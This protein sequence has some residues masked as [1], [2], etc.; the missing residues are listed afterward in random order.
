M[1]KENLEYW[2]DKDG[3]KVYGDKKKY[4][5]CLEYLISDNPD[6][7][8]SKH[9]IRI[10]KIFHP[11]FVKLLPLTTKN[12][13][14]VERRSKIPKGRPIIF[15]ASHGFRDDIALSL[16][17]IKKHAYLVYA[18]IPDFYY[19]IDGLALWANGVY[20]MDRKDKG[21][22]AALIPKVK[23]GFELGAKNV[24]ICSEGVWN[25]DPNEPILEL[26][27]GVYKM[28]Q[29]LNAVVMPVTT[30]NKDMDIDN[31]KKKACYS[32]LG[33]PIDITK[34]PQAEALDILRSTMAL[35]KIELMQKYSRAKR[36]DI[37]DPNVYWN[38][39]VQ[40]L[41]KTSNGL[42]DY[43]I[44][45]DAEYIPKEKIDEEDVF[46]PMKNV[47]VNSGNAKVYAKTYNVTGKQKKY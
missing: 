38:N 10:R 39:Y 17:T 16:K 27:P 15:V 35:D 21:S 40:E 19:S 24:L 12:K 4:N 22:K 34:Y 42:Y 3:N 6:D 25:K 46:A 2:Y 26:W 33:D 31:D 30:L 47:K 8:I 14:K 28:A 20:L 43:E 36:E 37:G 7:V 44:E 1:K 18:S 11:T 32:I 5:K 13:L 23:N 41:I 9:G 45:N 29:E